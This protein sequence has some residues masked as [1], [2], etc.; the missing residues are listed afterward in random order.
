MRSIFEFLI[1]DYGVCGYDWSHYIGTW[2][3]PQRGRQPASHWLCATWNLKGF[4]S[5][6]FADYAA[7]KNGPAYSQQLLFLISN[8]LFQELAE[9]GQ[10]R[11]VSPTSA[12]LFLGRHGVWRPE[13]FK[14]EDL[15]GKSFGG[16]KLNKNSTLGR[17]ICSQGD[18]ALTVRESLR[19]GWDF[20]NR[21]H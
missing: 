10:W 8:W 1:V 6:I 21:A 13:T 16:E 20:I 9:A 17:I 15:I 3:L 14:F 5:G 19:L 11:G 18:P 12:R 4:Q 7:A 2:I